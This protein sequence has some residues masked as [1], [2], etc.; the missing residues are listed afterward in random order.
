[1]LIAADNLHGLNAAVIKAMESLDAR[2][3]ELLVRQCEDH[4]ADYIDI[5]PGY[6]SPAKEDRIVF[7]VETVQKV[8]SLPLILD[9]PNPR[10]LRRGLEACNEPPILSALTLEKRKLQDLLGLAVE[11]GAE[12]VILL[13]DEASFSPATLEEKIAL[14][15]VLKEQAA[16]AGVPTQN[17]IFDPVLPSLSW[18]DSFLRVRETVKTVRFLSTGAVFQEPVRTMAGLSNLRSGFRRIF[19]AQIEYTCLTLLAGAG[20]DILLCDVLNP[21]LKNAIS[22]MQRYC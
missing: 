17:L 19:P 3:I 7:L 6:L 10:V 22:A 2:P 12:L 21:E 5:N 11:S 13:L 16:Q 4:G 1:M 8:T 20:L 14:A 15:T 9:S 18:D